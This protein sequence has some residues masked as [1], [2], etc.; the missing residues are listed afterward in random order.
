MSSLSHGKQYHYVCTHV[1]LLF[2][3]N[4]ADSFLKLLWYHFLF[5]FF[6]MF[7]AFEV[8]LNGFVEAYQIST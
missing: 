4:A 7:H 8:E 3:F 2:L 5:P 6:N 1:K